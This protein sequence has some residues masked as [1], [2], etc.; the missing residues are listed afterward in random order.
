MILTACGSSSYQ[1]ISV[2]EAEKLIENGDVIVIDVRT[3]DEYNEN[4][5][6]GSKLIPLQVIEDMSDE[7][8]KNSKYIIVCRSGNR[9]QQASDILAQK[10]FKNILNM[11][12][13]MNEWTGNIE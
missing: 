11:S 4:H 1:N 13:G 7:L 12:G 9:S 8:D 2:S 6:P 3:Q 10:G 5:I